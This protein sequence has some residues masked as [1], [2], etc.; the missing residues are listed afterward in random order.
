MVFPNA[1]E[2]DGDFAFLAESERDDL[3][4][5]ACAVWLPCCR[6]QY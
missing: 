5:S 6:F 4:R 2:F 1:N 3:I